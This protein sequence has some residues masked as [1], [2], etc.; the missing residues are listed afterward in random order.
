[1]TDRL[2]FSGLVTLKTPFTLPPMAAAAG[3]SVTAQRVDRLLTP[4]TGTP[5]TPSG[6]S[7]W[8]A[9][10]IFTFGCLLMVIVLG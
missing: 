8:S 5:W 1:M 10:A 3:L 4:S 7:I 9:L 6:W 2:A